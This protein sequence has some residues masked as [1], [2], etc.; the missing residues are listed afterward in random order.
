MKYGDLSTFPRREL[1]SWLLGGNNFK[2]PVVQMTQALYG[3]PDSVS[4]WEQHCNNEV[5]TV[6]FRSF[7]AEWPSVFFHDRLR[8]MLTIYVDDFKL[9]GPVENLTEGWALLRSRL[10]I[11]PEAKT[12]MYL[13]CNV[14]KQE[15]RLANGVMA[16]GIVY[17]ME[18]FLRQC[19]ERY[20]S[21]AGTKIKLKTAHTPFIAQDNNRSQFRNPVSK[22]PDYLQ[23]QV[24][25]FRG[26]R[27]ANYIG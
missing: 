22:D 17:D 7:G 26:W 24:V 12:G 11:G 25:W 21:L 9:A 18:A 10:E 19:V 20:L 13:G 27:C 16:R 15:I 6:G 4:W 1:Q 2:H 23:L 3:H 14:I 5:K 8:L